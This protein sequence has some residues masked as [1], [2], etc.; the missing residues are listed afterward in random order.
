MRRDNPSQDE[1]PDYVH[2]H[3][4]PLKAILTEPVVLSI[5]SHIW[6]S[7]V[8]MAFRAL[9]PL[10]YAT[11]IHLGGLGMLPATIGVFLGGFGLLN[12]IVQALF[13][14]KLVRRVGLR[15]IFLTCVFCFVPLFA[16]FPVISHFAREWGLSPAVR[17][18]AVFQLAIS[19]VTGMCFGTY[20]WLNA[21][22][23]LT[24][25][26]SHLSRLCF[27][28]HDILCGQS[29][30][31]RQRERHRTNR[32]L[33]RPG[34]GPSDGNTPLRIHA[35]DWFVRRTRGLHRLHRDVLMRHTHRIQASEERVGTQRTEYPCLMSRIPFGV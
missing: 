10:F 12:G 28:I 30:S 26:P 18:L 33:A 14:A 24:L 22:M 19:C 17:C 23:S 35:A 32:C 13:F 4:P 21:S 15:R 1:D 11:P 9:Q 34:V 2:E 3:V 16:M 7:F 20:S 29:T 27:P 25:S 8:D 31:T 5:S 6:L